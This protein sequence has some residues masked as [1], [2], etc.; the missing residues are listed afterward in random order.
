MS[1][2]QTRTVT[3]TRQ[4]TNV[5]CGSGTMTNQ[6]TLT[7]GGGFDDAV[8]DGDGEAAP[9]MRTA[10]A[11]TVVTGPSCVQNVQPHPQSPP[12]ADIALTKTASPSTLARNGNITY[13]ET[14]TNRGPDRATNVRLVDQLP[15]GLTLVSVSATQGGCSGTTSITCSLGSLAPG[16]TATITI[17]ARATATGTVQNSAAAGANE[18]DPSAANN[19]ASATVTV[20]APLRPPPHRK[21]ARHRGKHRHKKAPRFTGAHGHR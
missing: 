21:P 4:V 11:S 15:S 17:V 20:T 7:E 18:V 9:V 14:V 1:L 8:S 6:A 2:S 3:Y 13:T 12:T 19:T 5:G 10:A 16:A